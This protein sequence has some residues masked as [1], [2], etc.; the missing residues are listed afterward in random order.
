[1]RTVT[2]AR[3]ARWT[4]PVTCRAAWWWIR[5]SAGPMP[6]RSGAAT[7]TRSSTRCTSRGSR[8][9]HPGVPPELRGTYA[10]LAHEAS[11]SYLTD[12][13][14]TAVELL[15]VHQNVP[16]SFLPARG[17]TNYWGYNTVGYFAPH[18]G[19]S[20]AVRAGA[21]RRPGRRVQGH[22]GRAA[23]G[24]PRGA[25]GRGVQPHRRGRRAGA[26]AVLPRPGQPGLLPARPG[27]PGP[28]HRHH[29]LRQLAQRRGSPD[30]AADHGLA[31]LLDHRDACGR[32]PLRPGP[33]AGPAG[34]R[35]RPGVG[36]LRPGLPGSGGVPGQ[37]HRRA[38]GRGPDRQ[39]RPGPVP[40]AVAGVEREVPRQHARL[41]AQPPDRHRRVRHPVRRLGRPLQ[42]RGRGG[43]GRPRRS[44]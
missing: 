8:C 34:R 17:L 25:A 14:V 12:L 4:R 11:V 30:A 18:N 28:V 3:P 44:T 26:H 32:L 5:R 31:A 24:R 29:R 16:E 38:V 41:L 15:P 27:R 2:W 33:D 19:Y 37:A 7:R 36:V 23:R 40:A 21:A 20:A 9:A 39:L 22:G 43:G 10:G 42:R 35:L 13:G 1:M 6:R